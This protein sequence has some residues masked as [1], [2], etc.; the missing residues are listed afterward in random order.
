MVV[1]EAGG[2]SAPAGS[3]LLIC[4]YLQNAAYFYLGKKTLKPLYNI[5]SGGQVELERLFSSATTLCRRYSKQLHPRLATL[6]DI[7]KQYCP[8][9]VVISSDDFPSR[10]V[11]RA[12]CYMKLLSK[13]TVP[14]PRLLMDFLI[15]VICYCFIF[16]ITI[17]SCFVL[18][19]CII[20]SCCFLLFLIK[21]ACYG[22]ILFI[23]IILFAL[24]EPLLKVLFVFFV[25][26]SLKVLVTLFIFLANAA[27]TLLIALSVKMVYF[28]L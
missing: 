26:L 8:R 22:L 19:Y 4:V 16:L 14:T 10:G 21:V 12:V 2:F 20:I 15:K 9:G 24:L 6:L 17:I 11:K 13:I 23:A 7:F 28:M 27:C 18:L 1:S 25:L 3:F 5:N